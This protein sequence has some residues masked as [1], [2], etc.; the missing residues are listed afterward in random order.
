MPTFTL[1]KTEKTVEGMTTDTYG[2]ERD[3]IRIEDI[4]TNK[5]AVE[6]FIEKLNT[7]GDV[8]NCHIMD[9]IEDEFFC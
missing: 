5:T 3:A 8:S 1:V 4:S 2:I 9:L 6:A 7:V